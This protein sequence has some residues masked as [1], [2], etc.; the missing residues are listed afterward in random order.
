MLPSECP[1]CGR[2]HEGNSFVADP[3]PVQKHLRALADAALRL[4][5]EYENE[6]SDTY[7]DAVNA[8]LTDAEEAGLLSY[9]TVVQIGRGVPG[10]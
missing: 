6:R 5:G 9:E 4:V 7:S 3:G 8:A 2:L 1:N 10:A